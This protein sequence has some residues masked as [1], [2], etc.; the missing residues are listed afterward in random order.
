MVHFNLLGE[1]NHLHGY[2]ISE[3][4]IRKTDSKSE[5]YF[6]TAQF[7][8]IILDFFLCRRYILTFER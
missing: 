3:G 7:V 8:K 5:C 4:I 1:M 6:N 2:A